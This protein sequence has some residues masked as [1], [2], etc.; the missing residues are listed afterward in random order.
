[1]ARINTYQIDGSISANDIV[2]GS[3]YNG[4]NSTG[5]PIYK[6]KNYRM[7]DLQTFLAGGD[8]EFE[9]PIEIK[10]LP[11]G[12]KK[13]VHNNITVSTPSA[14][15]LLTHNGGT[16]GQFTVVTGVTTDSYTEDSLIVTKG[17]VKQINTTTYTLPDYKFNI[18]ADSNPGS[19]DAF[20]DINSSSFDTLNILGGT[21]LTSEITTG[22]TITINHNNI[23]HTPSDD[24]DTIN[25]DYGDDFTALTARVVSPQGHL[26]ASTKTTYSLP[27]QYSFNV[28]TDSNASHNREIT[29]GQTLNI[30]GAT[31]ISTAVSAADTVTISATDFT[32]PTTNPDV[33]GVRG[34]VPAPTTS[35]GSKFLKGNGGWAVPT[36]T[37]Y[38]VMGSGDPASYDAGL[39]LAGSATH[40]N[41]FLRKDG[42]W[43]T[44]TQTDISSTAGTFVS[45]TSNSGATGSV[46]V[47][48]DLS[49]SGLGSTTAAKQLQF[50]RGDNTWSN[51][52]NA[53]LENIGGL[54]LF[55]N[56]HPA[57]T[58]N[59][60]TTVNGRF[61]GLQTSGA[62]IGLVNVPWTDTNTWN[63]NT[64]TV[65]GYVSAP[66]ND[67]NKV[68][69]TDANGNPA[70][71]IDAD[72]TYSEA[73]SNSE[74][75][76]STAHH[77]KLDGIEDNA[78]ADQTAA[79]LRTAIGTGNGN[80]VPAEGT[81]GHF[82]KHD[83]TFGLP[84]YTTN[85]DT[86]TTYS[87]GAG[88]DLSGTTFSL[89]QT[90]LTGN[91]F[92]KIPF[93]SSNVIN[94]DSS[95]NSFSYNPSS[96]VL[97]VN[98]ISIG[99]TST[100]TSRSIYSQS[101]GSNYFEIA[102]TSTS[103][104]GRLLFGCTT[105]G[106]NGIYSRNHNNSAGREFRLIQLSTAV[107][108][109]A[110]GGNT[111]VNGTVTANNFIVT[112]DKRLKS[113]IEPIKKGLEVIKK[114]SSYNYIK[115]DEKESGFIAQEVREAIP[116][117]VYEN[118]EGY[119]SMS[120]RGVLAYM[121]KAIL[122]LEERLT[123]I[124]EKLN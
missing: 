10:P 5:I 6:T 9:A 49:A 8:F 99:T 89:T 69:K 83:G 28:S 47:N 11:A 92:F 106:F 50:L 35:D 12:N 111:T 13:W 53:T 114:F 21:V 120:D 15:S 22:D 68:W 113:E 23:T 31:P 100:L 110:T 46:T 56:T 58:I 52:N 38:S 93:M 116:H 70:W 71:R 24:G 121:H 27:A 74:G 67:A 95:A 112:S 78:T 41:N 118:N 124:E 59:T 98:K 105:S 25:L 57:N 39:V 45:I 34:L 97:A 17:H 117:T 94:V 16:N 96:N 18:A 64:K 33:S 2:I 104:G 85:T 77:D 66:G 81:A 3:E 80:L 79:Q 91:G 76:M 14:S 102:N 119:L 20:I 43:A 73:T 44:V 109:V 62:S 82:L 75:L 48:P 87:A 88:I 37:Q 1:M 90:T 32:G 65:A 29:S 42:S 86:N 60:A 51:V 26:T 40:N 101:S 4:I 123:A 61:Y 103:N 54:R 72:T 122:E 36:D 84:S 108:T 63:A 7:S 115:G 30:L 19:D 55:N 107:I